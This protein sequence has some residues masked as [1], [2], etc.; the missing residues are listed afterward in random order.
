MEVT[1][2]KFSLHESKLISAIKQKFTINLISCSFMNPK[3]RVRLILLLVG[4]GKEWAGPVFLHPDNLASA[5][6]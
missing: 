3:I 2:I 4:M 6:D 5:Q 1:I